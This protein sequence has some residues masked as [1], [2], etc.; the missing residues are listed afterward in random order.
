[1]SPPATG[2]VWWG[3]EAESRGQPALADGQGLAGSQPAL[4]TA[5][6]EAVRAELEAR[7]TGFT[8]AWTNPAPD[9]SGVALVRLFGILMESL[10]GQVN[11]LADKALVEY[12]R[13]AG[14]APL[15]ATAAE[16]LLTFTVAPAAGGSVSVPA[17]FQAG[18][19][20]GRGKR[21][22][23]HFRDRTIR[24]GHAR[25]SGGHRRGR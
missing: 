21:R 24:G 5:T 12:L 25:H 8:P 16:A 18:A 14:V 19:S 2:E 4:L 6:K 23:G 10:L 9:D 15:P 20:R 11:Q 17:G 22:P 7:I 13:I 1:M 3:R